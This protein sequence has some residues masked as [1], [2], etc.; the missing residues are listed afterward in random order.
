MTRRRLL[1]PYPRRCHRAIQSLRRTEPSSVE[2]PGRKRDGT[3]GHRYR[4]RE[5]SGQQSRSRAA[6][7]TS[8]RAEQAVAE[9]AEARQDETPGVELAIH[10]RREDRDVGV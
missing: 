4:L 3:R 7:S 6:W 2:E 9:V 10:R 5:G 1:S 8:L